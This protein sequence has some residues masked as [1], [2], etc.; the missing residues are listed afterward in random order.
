MCAPARSSLRIALRLMQDSRIAMRWMASMLACL[1]A[2]HAA[3]QSDEPPFASLSWQASAECI[4]AAEL[5]AAGTER[6]RRPAFA[7]GN[8]PPRLQR[9]TK[10]GEGWGD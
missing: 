3:A 5:E 9:P 4:S 10:R 2:A 6:P 7:P 1:I 8:S